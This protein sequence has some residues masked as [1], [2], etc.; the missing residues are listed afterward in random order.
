ME[1]ETNN[2]QSQIINRK[3]L[4]LTVFI[5][6]MSTLAIEFT[7]SRMLQTVYGTSNIVWANVIGLVLLFLTLG[8]FLGGKLA[9]KRPFPHTFYQLVTL[10]GFASVFFLLLTSVVLKSAAA[11][12]ADLQVGAIAGSLVVVVLALAIPVTLLGCMSPFAI[13]LAVQDVGEA[14]SV[15]GRIYATSTMGSLLGTYLPVLVTIPLLGSRITAVLF[16][17]ILMIIGL[18]GLWQTKKKSGIVFAMLALLLIPVILLW[19]RGDLKAYEG[20][21]FETESCLQLHPGRALGRL[22]LLAAKR[23]P[24]FP[25]LLL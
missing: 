3:Y 22:Q 4:Y 23:R 13:R 19:T 24:S 14:G 2:R 8:Y 21:I 17:T 12:M 11:A 15:S 20:Q 16:G 6:G 7:T 18:V 9:D 1:N 25:L 5:A 10:T